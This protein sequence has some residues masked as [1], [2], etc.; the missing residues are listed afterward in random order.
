MKRFIVASTTAA[1]LCSVSGLRPISFRSKLRES[2]KEES[3]LT[4]TRCASSS[5]VSVSDLRK[6][7]S[8]KGIDATDMPEDPYIVFQEWFR[9]ACNAKVL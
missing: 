7:Y 9:E 3:L 2:F 8:S 6:E 5:S 4:T 1:V